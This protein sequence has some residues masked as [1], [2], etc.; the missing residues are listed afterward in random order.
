MNEIFD[1]NRFGKYFQ[2]E[3]RNGIN[4]YGL[5]LL[6]T[7]VMPLIMYIF[8]GLFNLILSGSWV[9]ETG[10]VACRS[11][12]AV[13]AVVTLV[14]TTPVKLFGS[15]TEKRAGSNFLMLPA[16]ATE[17]FVS[18]MLLILVVVPFVFCTIFI[19]CDALINLITLGSYSLPALD[20]NRIADVADFDFGLN[21]GALSYAEWIEYAL[22]FTLGALYFKT[23]KVG[24]TFLVVILVGVVLS[25]LCSMALTLFD[26]ENLANI[27]QNKL[28]S[29]I[30]GQKVYDAIRMAGICINAAVDIALAAWVF[31]RIKTMKH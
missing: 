7:S 14:L 1:I 19:G 3:I 5:S 18:M 13:V 15:Y 21:I 20:F 17:K 28:G 8:Y 11:S 10:L 2:Y 25:L 26:F 29:G 23:G 9:G 31:I 6:I 4:N 30:D 24:K 12:A 22:I 27:I 16:S